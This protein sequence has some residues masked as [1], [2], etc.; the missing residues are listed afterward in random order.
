MSY[1]FILLHRTQTRKAAKEEA[2]QLYCETGVKQLEHTIL[3]PQTKHRICKSQCR[4]PLATTSESN[5]KGAQIMD[6]PII[7]TSHFSQHR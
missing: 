5:G 4:L 2:L 3:Q 1:Y 7:S 6:E